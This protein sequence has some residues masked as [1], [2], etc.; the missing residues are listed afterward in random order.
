VAATVGAVACAVASFLPWARSGSRVRDSHEL[1]AVAGRLD[2]IPPA[3]TRASAAWS[4]VPLAA[5]LTCVAMA[6]RRALPLGIISLTVGIA[7]IS[8]AAVVLSSPLGAA[9]GARAAVLTGSL[10]IVGALIVI[11][12]QRRPQ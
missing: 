11:A 8:L 7:S 2:L 4:L 3:W 12:E 5:V 9:L 10:S 1:V 6:Y